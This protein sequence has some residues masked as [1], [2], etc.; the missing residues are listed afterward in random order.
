[1]F[2][3]SGCQESAIVKRM[4]EGKEAAIDFVKD[5]KKGFEDK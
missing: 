5:L 4:K 2:N 3:V 1:M